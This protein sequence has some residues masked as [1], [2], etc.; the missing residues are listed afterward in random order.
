MIISLVLL[1]FLTAGCLLLASPDTLSA[2]LPSTLF[3]RGWLVWTSCWFQSVECVIP[4]DL[5]SSHSVCDLGWANLV[6]DATW[7]NLRIIRKVNASCAL[8]FLFSL[9]PLW[10]C[11]GALSIFLSY[12]FLLLG[13]CV[14]MK[15]DTLCAWS[16]LLERG[17]QNMMGWYHCEVKGKNVHEVHEHRATQ[18]T[19]SVNGAQPGSAKRAGWYLLAIIVLKIKTKP[20]MDSWRIYTKLILANSCDPQEKDI[21][22]RKSSG[23]FP[24]LDLW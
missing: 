10:A 15:S 18:S 19:C 6:G 2:L 1:I 24:S 13:K 21:R 12:A 20:L 8:M 11:W 23:S 5:G 17:I 22:T 14:C 3:T 16:P 7:A 4:C 9:S